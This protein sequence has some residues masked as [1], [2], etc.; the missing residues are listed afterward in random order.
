MSKES[1][2]VLIQSS[3]RWGEVLRRSGW[4]PRPRGRLLALLAGRLASQLELQWELRT[5][6]MYISSISFLCKTQSLSEI[7]GDFPLLRE[8]AKNARNEKLG[9]R[10]LRT[11]LAL[12]VPPF[13]SLL[14]SS[15]SSSISSLGGGLAIT[16]VTPC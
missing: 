12:V 5:S 15:S 8:L 4:S 7:N 2:M 10:V 11:S 1:D 16:A 9:K 13:A 6:H 14:S 3:A